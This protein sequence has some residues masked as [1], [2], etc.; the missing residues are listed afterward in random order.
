MNPEE[1]RWR[2]LGLW[3]LWL[4]RPDAALPRQEAPLQTAPE[5]PLARAGS[6]VS[7]DF[8]AAAGWDELQTL[9][10]QCT[11]CPLHETRQQA[12][13][14]VG[15]RQ[16]RWMF[17]GE[18]PGAEEDQR[19]EPFVGAAGRL[20]D[21]MLRAVGLNRADN[22]YIANV[23]KCRPPQN[24]TPSDP[25]CASCMPY[26]R[27]QIALIKPTLIVALGKVAAHALLD[28]DKTLGALRGK[29][30]RF[31]DIPVIVTW[32]PAYLLRNPADKAKSWEDLCRA[33][34]L[35]AS[36][37]TPRDGSGDTADT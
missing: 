24:R 12:V 2:E 22:V 37:C 35:L 36:P 8:V 25:E 33:R 1:A 5:P 14:G 21:Q 13:F 34:Q 16:A 4:P 23:V 27:R 3:P 11:R 15:D 19:G 32:H 28:T 26:L 6:G 10:H 20:L 31:G 30:H 7:E 29:L 9:V 18:G 17:V